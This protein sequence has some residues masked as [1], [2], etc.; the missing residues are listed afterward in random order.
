MIKDLTKGH[1]VKSIMNISLP[2]MGASLFQTAYQLADMAFLGRLSSESVAAVGTAGMYLHTNAALLTLIFIGT[3]IKISHSAGKKELDEAFSYSFSAMVMTLILTAITAV[4]MFLFSTSL[5][6][7]FQL[8]SEYIESKGV[9]YLKIMALFSLFANMSFVMN[10]VF[11]GFGSARIPFLLSST[12]LILNI[13]L[14]PLFIFTLNMGVEGA[15]WATVISQGLS[16][17]FFLLLFFQ[18]YRKSGLKGVRP[19][20]SKMAEILKLGYPVTFQRLLFSVINIGIGRI[21]AQWGPVPIAVQKI[22]VQLESASWI[23]AGGMQGALTSFVGQNYAVKQFKRIKKGVTSSLL[24]MAGTGLFVTLIFTLIPEAL[25]SLFLRSEEEIL[26]GAEYLRILAFSQILMCLEITTMGAFNGLGKT[27]IPPVNSMIFTSLR[28]PLAL[29]LAHTLMM[30]VSGVWWSI[31][32]T[33][34]VKGTLLTLLFFIVLRRKQF[35][36][37]H[38]IHPES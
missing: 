35:E 37:L 22:G 34:M 10:R 16:T 32:L 9:S 14:D 31:T 23:T 2:I 30:G 17:A 6:G 1:I 19:S 12:G 26:K 21:I 18:N 20:K 25:F 24:I 27:G 38:K 28:I 33:S 13:C 11:L 7:F 8:Q 36:Q 29:F 3:G 15:A 4:I 5:I